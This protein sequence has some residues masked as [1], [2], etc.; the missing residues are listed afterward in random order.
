M[1]QGSRDP[2]HRAIRSR[3]LT[4][5]SMAYVLDGSI[6]PAL[7]DLKEALGLNSRDAIAL[8]FQAKL[9]EAMASNATQ[10]PSR[11][12]PAAESQSEYLHNSGGPNAT[13]VSEFSNTVGRV[14][15]DRPYPSLWKAPSHN[16]GPLPEPEPE[17]DVVPSR[18]D[19][20][21]YRVNDL[22]VDEY[23]HVATRELLLA[24]IDT[25]LDIFTHYAKIAS[26]TVDEEGRSFAQIVPHEIEQDKL[27][28]LAA[29]GYR[30]MFV[31]EG[32]SAP[33]PTLMTLRQFWQLSRDCAFVDDHCDLADI[34]RIVT[35]AGREIA[36]DNVYFERLMR[37]IIAH[38]Q[39][40]GAPPEPEPEPEPEVNEDEDGQA[41]KR[42]PLVPPAVAHAVSQRRIA[43][44][45]YS[46]GNS[47]TGSGRQLSSSGRE[48]SASLSVADDLNP[49]HP[50][51]RFHAYEYVEALVR[52]AARYCTERH[53]A[54]RGKGKS[55]TTHA[56][57]RTRA[58]AQV[59]MTH[60]MHSELRAKLAH[61]HL[62]EKG[63]EAGHTEFAALRLSDCLHA[64]LCDN[65]MRHSCSHATMTAADWDFCSPSRQALLAEY[66]V[67]LE[68]IFRYYSVA[69]PT[70]VVTQRTAASGGANAAQQF[71][72][73]RSLELL[74]DTMDF[75]ELLTWL[76][77]F[78]LLDGDFTPRHAAKLFTRITGTDEIIAQQ[79]KNNRDSEMVLDEWIEF[80]F[81]VALV[82]TQPRQAAEPKDGARSKRKAKGGLSASLRI[83]NY[84]REVIMTRAA[85]EMPIDRTSFSKTVG[86]HE[87][88]TEAE[89]YDAI[90]S[91]EEQLT[92]EAIEEKA[93]DSD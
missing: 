80:L 1:L 23:D 43:V 53:L 55:K 17:P 79:H 44:M 29:Q 54:K 22:I 51:N 56:V 34:D 9:R 84:L 18:W 81:C 67:P 42:P 65:I 90:D 16:F 70:T 92:G 68:R 37:S 28:S 46:S 20:I 12:V 10:S 30:T 88:V 74:D 7:A 49:H 59:G 50:N 86:S 52:C 77:K 2:K 33:P 71:W 6:E 40:G 13:A 82:H 21:L 87:G 5:R 14:R 69:R 76:E 62:G 32:G 72:K 60:Q 19:Y 8:R 66:R 36:E 15:R 73:T 91:E 64:F 45:A 47:L 4:Y 48:L 27:T 35:L 11:F 41:R 61:K 25:L 83:R 63:L 78:D 89:W 24:H 75:N 58:T 85:T 3:L 26:S 93:T 38:R 57:K 31:E 39:H